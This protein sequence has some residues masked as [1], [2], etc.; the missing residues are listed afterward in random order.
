MTFLYIVL[1]TVAGGVLSILAAALFAYAVLSRFVDRMVSFSVGMLLATALLNI[2]PEAFETPGAPVHV[3]FAVLLAGL[4][5]FFVL[6][7]LALLRHSHHHEMDGH[8]HTHGH[9]AME[10]GRG[11]WLIL[12]G[13]GLHNFCDGILIAA[14]FLTDTRLGVLTTI[15]IVAH[16]VPQEVGDFMILLNAGLTKARAFVFNMLSSGAAVLGGILGFLFLDHADRAVPYVLVVAASS[17]LYIAVADLIPQLNRQA[18]RRDSL[19][20]VTLI[21]VGVGVVLTVSRF[22]GH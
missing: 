21:A 3:L 20:Q 11:G 15:S 1:A 6:Q 18:R 14:A 17:F 2:L 9:D 5:G 4:L 22:V 10:A 19:I 8:G 13:D 7:K 16:E 12:I